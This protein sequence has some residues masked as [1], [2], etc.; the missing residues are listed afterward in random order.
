MALRKYQKDIIVNT[1]YEIRSNGRGVEQ[2]IESLE[3]IGGQVSIYGSQEKPLN[4][5]L[6]MTLSRTSFQTLE[7]FDVIPNYLYL[8]ETGGTVTRATLSGVEALPI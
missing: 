3:V 8:Q 2:I 6:E 5:P 7:A 4:P 1:L